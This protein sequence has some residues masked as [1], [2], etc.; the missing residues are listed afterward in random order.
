MRRLLENRLL[1]IALASAATRA[2]QPEKTRCNAERDTEPEDLQHLVAHRGVNV[3]GLQSGVED[4]GEYAVYCC[5]G[6]GGG[7]GEDTRCLGMLG[8]VSKCEY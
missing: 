2:E 6:C 5:G 4:T 3:V 1:L 8:Q 7:D